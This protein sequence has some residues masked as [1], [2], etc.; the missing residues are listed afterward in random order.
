MSPIPMS[1]LSKAWVCGYSHAGIVSSNSAGIMDVSL[2]CD[3]FVL[4]GGGICVG[5]IAR[6]EES[7]PNVVCVTGCDR[8][9]SIK[10][11][12]WPNRDSC[13]Q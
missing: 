3:C 6:R 9:A 1:A 5:L 13:A 7:F 10:R 8:E 2:S 12:P 11:R 4:S